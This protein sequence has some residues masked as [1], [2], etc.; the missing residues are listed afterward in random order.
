MLLVGLLALAAGVLMPIMSGNIQGMTFR[1]I[2]AAGAALTF[3]ARMAN[4]APPRTV[5]L[6]IRRL[7][8][9]ES[10]SSVLFCVAA[11]F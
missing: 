9:L 10:W 4:P 5:P 2:F 7:L 11:F 1:Y 8:R 3:I 6:R